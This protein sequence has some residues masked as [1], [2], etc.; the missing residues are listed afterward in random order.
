MAVQ[1]ECF[2][3][4]CPFMVRAADRDEIVNLVQEHATYAHDLDI[5][6]EAIESE[7]ERA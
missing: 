7:I 5:E 6:R 2:Q 3:E 4:G 1:F